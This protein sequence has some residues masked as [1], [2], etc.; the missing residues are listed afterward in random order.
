MDSNSKAE[1]RELA[2]RILR[3]WNQQ[4]VE[5]VVECYAEDLRYRD[6]NTRG[7]VEGAP[8]LRRYLTKLFANWRM[9][10]EHKESFPLANENGYAVLWRATFQRPAGGPVVAADGIDLVVMAGDCI[11][12]NEVYFDRAVLAP[13]MG[14]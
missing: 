14:Q 5:K 7:Y 2:E 3:P 9:T 11:S 6:P 10:W 8:A 12:R 13:F 4:D 1:I